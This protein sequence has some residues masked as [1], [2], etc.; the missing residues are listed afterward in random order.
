M[1]S[2]GG[3]FTLNGRRFPLGTAVIR[4]AGEPSRP[5]RAADG[6][7]DE[8]RRRDRADRHRPTSSRAPRSAATRRRSSRRRACCWRGTRR[9]RRSPPAGRATCSSAASV[10]RSR[11][12]APDRWRAPNLADFDVIVL[13][14]GNYGGRDQRAV[15]NRLKDWLRAGGT[16]ITLAEATRWATGSNVGLLEHDGAAQ[17]RQAGHAAVGCRWVRCGQV[18]QVGQVGA[19]AGWWRGRRVSGTRSR[20]TSTTTRRFSPIASGRR[21]SRAR[22][23]ASRSTRITGSP[24]ASD[25]ETQAMIEGNARLRADQAR[26][27]GATSASRRR[28]ID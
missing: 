13:P 9:P 20:P 10:S 25:E 16:L 19:G 17:G 11:P 27:A 2:V 6:A 18:G 24:R 12:C 21:R 8:A 26:T 15:L 1:R 14:S 23:C 3:A 7:G 28:R 5:A 22:S 4:V